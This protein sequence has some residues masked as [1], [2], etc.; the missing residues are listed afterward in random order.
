MAVAAFLSDTRVDVTPG[1]EATCEVKVRNTGQVVDQF[2]VELL[3][4]AAEWAVVEPPL[5]NLLPGDESTARI[6]FTPPRAADVAAGP[7]PFG[8]RVQSREDPHGST[9]AEGELDIAPFTDVFVEL[10]PPK[11]RG[12]RKA[13]FRLVVDNNGNQPSQVEIDAFDPEDALEIVL[14]QQVLDTAAGTTTWVKTKVIPHK[15]FVK[16]SPRTHPFQIVAQPV[17]RQ[18]ITADGVMT[19]EQLLP[20]WLL[21]VAALV[22]AGVV[23]LV[24]LWF[25]LVRPSV[26]T[27]AR[28]NV[29]EQIR[30]AQEASQRAAD[31]ERKAARAADDANDSA[32]AAER[33]ADEANRGDPVRFRLSGTTEPVEDGSFRSFRYIAP[34]DKTLAISD[35]ILQNPRGDFGYLR[36]ILDGKV[37]LEVGL[38]NIRDLDY[39]YL[40]PLIVPPNKPVVLAVNCT[41]PGTAT[42]DGCTP[43]ASFSG[44]LRDDRVPRP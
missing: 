38:A 29:S 44:R 42:R 40:E 30:Q 39:H 27:A 12:R 3:G 15:R 8:V 21:P 7:Q 41:S 16:G 10:V 9:V 22:V 25:A 4:D 14:D 28:E 33:F 31:A 34:D 37:E 19:Q 35:I 2:S 20:R 24:V 11:G 36:I 32:K 17:G 5:I 26:Q 23:A 6:I 13:K 1:E 43:S 18:P